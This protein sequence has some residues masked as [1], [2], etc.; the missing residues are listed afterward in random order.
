MMTITVQ[1]TCNFSHLYWPT[2]DLVCPLPAAAA[3]IHYLTY[4]SRQQ[5]LYPLPGPLTMT[6]GQL[7]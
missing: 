5:M 7:P 1:L 6:T 4:A 3:A 2:T